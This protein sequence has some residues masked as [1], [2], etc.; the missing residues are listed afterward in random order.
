[1]Y[2]SYAAS[3][4]R[5]PAAAAADS[6]P[7]APADAD[8]IASA[9]AAAAALARARIAASRSARHIAHGGATTDCRIVSYR[10]VVNKLDGE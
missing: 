10:I 9:A 8:S 6:I 2:S 4:L 5:L 1:M 3:A 7:A